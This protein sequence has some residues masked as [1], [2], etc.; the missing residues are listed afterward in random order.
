MLRASE[1]H[2]DRLWDASRYLHLDTD[3]GL[4]NRLECADPLDQSD[5]NS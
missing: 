5:P 3:G 1:K 4:R 2:D